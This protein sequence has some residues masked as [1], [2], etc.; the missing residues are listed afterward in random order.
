MT[1]DGLEPGMILHEAI[2]PAAG[3]MLLA[4]GNEVT[5]ALIERLRRYAE[6]SGVSEPIKALIPAIDGVA[7]NHI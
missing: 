7:R 1:V 6:S 4:A 2:S 3:L 5:E